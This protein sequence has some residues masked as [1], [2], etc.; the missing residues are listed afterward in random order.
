MPNAQSEFPLTLAEVL[1]EEFEATRGS[2][3]GSQWDA[4]Q[5]EIEQI[6]EKIEEIRALPT[7]ARKRIEKI[8]L[9]EEIK[10]DPADQELSD[11]IWKCKKEL[12]KKLVPRL[13]GVIRRRPGRL[14]AL[15]L[16]GGGV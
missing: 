1:F 16:S 6:E 14:S 2:A 11:L 13:Y 15:C 10:G 5:K 12:S 8:W 9:R 7:F 3:S 4:I